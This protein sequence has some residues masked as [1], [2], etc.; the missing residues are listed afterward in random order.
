M[1]TRR[2]VGSAGYPGI[3]TQVDSGEL[4][5][6]NG[7]EEFWNSGSVCATFNVGIVM[8]ELRNF[9]LVTT[10]L[11]W[12]LSVGLVSTPVNDPGTA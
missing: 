10:M 12:F 8:V 11:A 6:G 1:K 2:K 9:Q 5:M 7:A 3:L 4:A